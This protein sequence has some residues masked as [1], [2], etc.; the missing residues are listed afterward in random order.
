MALGFFWKRSEILLSQ[1]KEALNKITEVRKLER[2][3]E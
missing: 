3:R 1:N 2:E